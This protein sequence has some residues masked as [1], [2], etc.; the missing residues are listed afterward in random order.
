MLFLLQKE[1]VSG[2]RFRPIAGSSQMELLQVQKVR[3]M[4]IASYA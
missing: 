3:D 4:P 1:S 2:G